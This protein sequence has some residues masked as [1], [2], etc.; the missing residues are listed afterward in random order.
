MLICSELTNIHLRARLRGKVDAL[1]VP[2]WNQDLTTFN[3]LV[4]SAVLDIHA[5]IVQ[6]NDRAYGDSRIRS[7]AKADWQ[8]DLVRAKGGDEDFFVTT[9][10]DPAPLR[11]FQSA[12]RSRTDENAPYKPTPD[13]FKDDMGAERR[14][15]PR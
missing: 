7:P 11:E 9:T 8:R 14:Q 15:L 2:A 12:H 6:C 4:E 5:F 10:I 3:A 13:G 1:I